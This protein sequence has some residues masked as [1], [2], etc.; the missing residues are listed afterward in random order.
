[1]ALDDCHRCDVTRLDL[2]GA[3]LSRG[4]AE[5]LTIFIERERELANVRYVV[6]RPSVVCRLSVCRL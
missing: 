6:V 5:L 1:M 2:T 4:D 3:V